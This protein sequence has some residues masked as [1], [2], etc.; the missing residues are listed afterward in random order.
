MINGILRWLTQGSC[1]DADAVRMSAGPLESLLAWQKILNGN[2][3]NSVLKANQ[4]A[5]SSTFLALNLQAFPFASRNGVDHPGGRGS[6]AV[7]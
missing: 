4:Q 3:D 6:A 5:A 7:A 2:F 1:L